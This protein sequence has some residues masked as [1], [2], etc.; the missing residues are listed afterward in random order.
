METVNADVRENGQD[1]DEANDEE[2]RDDYEAY[3]WQLHAS[4]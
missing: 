3:S 2:K 1:D 4:A